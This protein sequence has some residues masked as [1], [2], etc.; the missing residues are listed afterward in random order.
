[1]N[2]QRTNCG[3]KD[4]RSTVQWIRILTVTTFLVRKNWTPMPSTSGSYGKLVDEIK[5]DFEIFAILY[6]L[7]YLDFYFV[8]ISAMLLIVLKMHFNLFF[9][10]EEY[11][12]VCC[13]VCK[14]WSPFFHVNPY[15]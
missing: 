9:S 6:R 12:R 13:I 8:H 3:A 2:D 15:Y 7:N 4:K 11:F 1:M 10:S 14:I 5:L